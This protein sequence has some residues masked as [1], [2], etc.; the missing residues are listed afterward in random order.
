MNSHVTCGHSLDSKVPLKVLRQTI[1]N[2]LEREGSNIVGYTAD[3]FLQGSFGH[4]RVDENFMVSFITEANK[5]NDVPV[6][7]S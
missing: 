3:V 2:H 7:N 4:E 5:V 1:W 6:V